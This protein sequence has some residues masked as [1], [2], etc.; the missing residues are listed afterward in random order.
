MRKRSATFAFALGLSLAA[1][2]AACS[3]TSNPGT[4]NPPG[5]D[6][7]ASDANGSLCT[8][9]E[10]VSCFCP[11]G[12]SFGVTVCSEAGTSFSACTGCGGDAGA[13]ATVDANGPPADASTDSP[14][15][16]SPPSPATSLVF[17]HT[18]PGIPP[19][20]LCLGASAGSASLSVV[21]LPAL[22]DS[23]ST[24]PSVPALGPF[25]AV[26]S[27][28]P[29]A[30]P[31][32]I[33]AL[34]SIA[35]LPA[36]NLTFF[37]VL[38]SSVT[39]DVSYDGGVGV[40]PDGGAQESCVALLG[41]HGLGTADSP[42]GRLVAG[43]DFFPLAPIPAGTFATSA[44]F[45]LTMTG[46]LPGAVTTGA[47]TCGA[48]YDG[49]NN[50]QIG[51]AQLDTTTAPDGGIGAQFAHRSSALEGT[52]FVDD[53]GAVV[54][55]AATS[56]VVP[57][58][59]TPSSTIVPL[60]STEPAIAFSA[61]GLVPSTAATIPYDP[62]DAGIS[63]GVLLLP[64]DGGAP[65]PVPYPAGDL[66]S[67]PLQTVDLLSNWTSSTTLAS[68][69]FAAGVT[70]TFVLTGDPSA[71]PLFFPTTDGGAVTLNPSYDGRGLHFVAF[72]NRFTPS[73]D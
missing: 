16:S 11:N 34:P 14:V 2:A 13:D 15:D 63:F 56:G 70:Y 1:I 9:G 7:G 22:P 35:G 58:F 40:G 25:P 20:R 43:A 39:G 66:L 31:G 30:F 32:A 10:S 53:A 49:G 42:P 24:S 54:H 26:A 17:A 12:S 69:S 37:A 29:G 19:V 18:A 5:G 3:T 33:G 28:T 71:Q 27:G 21:P 47:A 62:A 64:T 61:S 23:P 38:A 57:V 68:S 46:C 51:V 67:L 50:A 36:L 52:P 41:Q 4:G 55:S 73:S 65:N 59:I 72:P 45:L 8:P 60:Q 6:S 44:S 48:G